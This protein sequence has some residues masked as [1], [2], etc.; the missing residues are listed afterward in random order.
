MCDNM[1]AELYKLA[2]RT[3][4]PRFSLGLPGTSQAKSGPM[5]VS[6]ELRGLDKLG[7]NACIRHSHELDCCVMRV[8]DIDLLYFIVIM[9][10]H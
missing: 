8:S 10:Y 7:E 5:L 3:L 4:V 6:L 9:I 2:N 1:L